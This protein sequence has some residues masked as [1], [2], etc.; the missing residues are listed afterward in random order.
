MF[1]RFTK[2]FSR[3]VRGFIIALLMLFAPALIATTV[4]SAQRNKAKATPTPKKK[5]AAPTPKKAA[6]AKTKPTP[7]PTPNKSKTN[8]KNQTPAASKNKTASKKNEKTTAAKTDRKT[9][10]RSKNSKTANT[11][12]SKQTLAANNKIPSKNA[13]SDKNSKTSDRNKNSSS[14]NTRAI[15]AE[16]NKTKP[17]T[18][19]TTSTKTNTKK[20]P[21]TTADTRSKNVNTTKTTDKTT[22][23]TTEKTSAE[24]PQIIVTTFSVPLRSQAK[25]D[26]ATL[27]NV[28]LGTILRVTEKNPAW[29]KVQYSAGGQ[30]SVGWVSANSVNDLNASGKTEI[31]RQIVERN[32]KP[33][34]DFESASE[35][36]EFLSN[37][38]G[39]LD[40][41]D[42]SAEIEL[43]RLLAL[44]SALKTIP[45]DKRE[46]SPYKE[47]LKTQEKEI[48][49]NEPAGQWLVVSNEFWDLHNKY[50]KST[51]SDAIAWEA[52]NNP[53]PGECEGYVNCYLFDMRMRFGEYLN[54]H[55]N[56]KNAA[57]ALK[58]TTDYLSPIVADL[59]AKAVYHGPS[60][61]TDRAE[62]NNLI[63]EL[64]TIIARLPFVEKEKTLQQL[65]QIAEAYR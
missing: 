59:Q 37:A 15:T 50:K 52:A 12:N 1:L 33:Q 17:T 19:K 3:P 54:L 32:Y 35:F 44:R 8:S 31:Y 38:R 2:K 48:V 58:N 4:E 64:R 56:G 13:K 26:A 36:Y 55:P 43:K 18:A 21:K 9:T 53:L 65:R 41:S 27:S 39:E 61:V 14:K 34:M 62:F 28:K 30:T 20:T 57:E 10:D 49:Y 16:K 7:K 24:L 22:D 40:A 63:A 46:N 6:Q 5:A 25:P 29:Y 23:K 47:F 42:K 45:T 51:V 11:K 60:D